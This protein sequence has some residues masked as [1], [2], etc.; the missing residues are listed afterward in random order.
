M[1]LSNPGLEGPLQYDVRM[2]LTYNENALRLLDHSADI[3]TLT[4]REIRAGKLDPLILPANGTR[5]NKIQSLQITNPL[6]VTRQTVLEYTVPVGYYGVINYLAA[7]LS[8]PYDEG[9]G[10]VIWSLAANDF[11]FYGYGNILNTLGD[12]KQQWSVDGGLWIRSNQVIRVYIDLPNTTGSV[13]APARAT[14]A[15]QGWIAPR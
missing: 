10:D 12:L 2:S 1:H 7:F 11:F 6:P 4:N 13:Q 9:S 8:T 15:I 14:G 3:Q 5:L